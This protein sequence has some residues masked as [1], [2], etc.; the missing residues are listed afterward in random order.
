MALGVLPTGLPAEENAHSVLLGG[1]KLFCSAGA[2]H[3]TT[4]SEI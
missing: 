4:R 3:Y 1:T 2:K